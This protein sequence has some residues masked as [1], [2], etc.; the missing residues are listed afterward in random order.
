[1]PLFSSRTELVG[2][3]LASLVCPGGF[4]GGSAGKNSA[5]NAGDHP[6]HRRPGLDPWVGKT[7]WRSE[8]QPL[9]HSCLG[10]PMDTG[11]W[12]AIA[13]GVGKELVLTGR[14][15]PAVFSSTSLFVCPRMKWHPT[16]VLLP[17][18]SQGQG[19]L[20]GCCPWGRTESDTTEGTQQQQRQRFSELL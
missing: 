15:G 2:L 13:L 9:Q 5:H 14:L 17:G 1:M 12:E 4:P 7:P 3:L 18:E 20:V 10:N 11:A 16:P 8:W 6:Q 19:S